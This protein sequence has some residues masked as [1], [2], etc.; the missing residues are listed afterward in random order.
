MN[1]ITNG[2]QALGPRRRHQHGRSGARQHVCK[3][4]AEATRSPGH[5]SGSPAQ[6]DGVAHR[7]SVRRNDSIV[8]VWPVGDPAAKHGASSDE[9]PDCAPG[10]GVPGRRQRRPDPVLPGSPTS[11]LL[12]ARRYFAQ[13]RSQFACRIVALVVIDAFPTAHSKHMLTDGSRRPA[14]CRDSAAMCTTYGFGLTKTTAQRH[15]WPLDLYTQDGQ[16]GDRLS[17]A[18][19]TNSRS[20]HS[21]RLRRRRPG[22]E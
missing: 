4:A 7:H 10:H 8:L 14:R 19:A 3:I 13:V 11:G 12:P 22:L 21:D 15:A 18:A 2:P 9:N 1:F 5:Q 17:N 6:Y 16:A 20:G